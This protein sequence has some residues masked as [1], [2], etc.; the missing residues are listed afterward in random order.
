MRKMLSNFRSQWQTLAWQSLYSWPYI[1]PVITEF[2]PTKGFRKHKLKFALLAA[3]TQ[4]WMKCVQGQISFQMK[5]L[6]L[7]F[8][9]DCHSGIRLCRYKSWKLHPGT[10]K[11]QQEGLGQGEWR[12]HEPRH[13]SGHIG[14]IIVT[15]LTAWWWSICCIMIIIH[16]GGVFMHNHN[17]LD[18]LEIVWLSWGY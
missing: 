15:A 5:F 2:Y 3:D 18:S 4:Q 12:H 1:P 7:R 16:G 14:P 13:S 11:A 8:M 17:V 6:S 10:V 9:C